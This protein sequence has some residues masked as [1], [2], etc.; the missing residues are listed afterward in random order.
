MGMLDILINSNKTPKDGMEYIH[1]NTEPIPFGS[2]VKNVIKLD[3]D[4][5]D[6]INK[7]TGV[8][9]HTNYG[10]ALAENTPENVQRLNDYLE[11][12]KEWEALHKKVKELR[13]KVIDL[14]GPSKIK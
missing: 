2:I 14:N 7:D 1:L 13:N 11:L 6:F 12:K 9:Y 4:S 5:F 3:N 8:K 10:W